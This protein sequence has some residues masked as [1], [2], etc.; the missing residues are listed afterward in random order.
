MGKNGEYFLYVVQ[1]S[2]QDIYIWRND[3]LGWT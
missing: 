2:L 1:V 3:V